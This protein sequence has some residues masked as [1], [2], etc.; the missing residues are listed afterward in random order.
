MQQERNNTMMLSCKGVFRLGSFLKKHETVLTGIILALLCI[1]V[2]ARISMT[3]EK[4]GYNFIDARYFVETAK[5][6]LQGIS[7]YNPETNPTIFKYP[8]QAPSMSLLSMP[9]CF[10]PGD[11]PP[12]LFFYLGGMIAFFCFTFLVFD[13]Y[14]FPF[15]EQFKLRWK[16]LPT[17]IVFSLIF[18]SSPFLLMLRH[19]QNSSFAAFFLFLALLYPKRDRQGNILFL[20]LSAAIKYSLLT[21]QMPVLLIQKRW[22]LCVFSF[23]LF[24]FMVLVVGFWL[25]GIIPAIRDY[26]VLVFQ[27]IKNGTNSYSNKN[28]QFFVHVGFFRYGP[29]NTI[30]KVFLLALY[31]MS[32][33]I[34]YLRGKKA[35]NA[36]PAGGGMPGVTALEWGAFTALTMAISYHRSYDGILFVP[37]LGVVFL[38][39]LKNASRKADFK[40]FDLFCILGAAG[41]LLFWAMPLKTVYAMEYMLGDLFPGGQA[42]F[43]CPK[44]RQG[45]RFPLSKF[46]MI[47]TT[48]FLFALELLHSSDFSTGTLSQN[49]KTE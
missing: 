12:L 1:L 30:I 16:N 43:L 47:G 24:L 39:M 29:V 46:V 36:D 40:T 14:G 49:E 48:V 41:L 22:R 38:E 8:L 45:I 21:M 20:G 31:A 42:V 28:S 27:D 10:L 13:F 23:L 17:W 11:I 33:R 2:L 34:I 4:R 15:G 25:D 3:W 35:K 18:T 19:G 26:V 32:L 6:I 44:N 7:P 5:L 37:F 9:I